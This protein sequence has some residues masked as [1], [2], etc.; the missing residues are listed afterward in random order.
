MTVLIIAHSVRDGIKH[1]EMTQV[2][3]ALIMRLYIQMI[4][5]ADSCKPH[6]VIVSHTDQLSP[7]LVAVLMITFA[8]L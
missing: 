1:I 4:N 8:I 5:M 7:K 6:R 3:R 2:Q